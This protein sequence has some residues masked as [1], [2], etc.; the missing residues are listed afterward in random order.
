MIDQ[1]R[2]AMPPPRFKFVQPKPA[3]SRLRKSKIAFANTP[4]SKTGPIKA[5]EL[6]S[7]L[8][9]GKKVSTQKGT[10]IRKSD[11]KT[12]SKTRE[13]SINRA[14]SSLV[15]DQVYKYPSIL[16]QYSVTLN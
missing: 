13:P 2:N 12:K 15:N 11:S 10:V 3:I 5:T 6:S 9:V 4:L 14:S 7:S 16:D 8:T 1:K